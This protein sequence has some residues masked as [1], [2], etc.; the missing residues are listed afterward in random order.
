MNRRHGSAVFS[1]RKVQDDAEGWIGIHLMRDGGAGP[2]RVA[3]VTF[4]D[5]VGQF[6]I[7]VGSETPLTIV[8]EMVAEARALVPDA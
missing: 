7:V 8:E 1:T 3:S 6:S 5:A 4:W 2:V